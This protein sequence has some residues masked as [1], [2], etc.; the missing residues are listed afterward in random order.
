MAGKRIV[1]TAEARSDFKATLAFY[2]ERNGSSTY[3]RKLASHIL[4]AIEKLKDHS[5]LGVK[6][7]DPDVRILIT[8]NFSIYYEPREEEILVL[9]I[10]DAR[11]DPEELEKY[12]S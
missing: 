12:L 9:I 5:Y 1:W 8:G 11:R 2:R 4:Q 6:T 3:S 10:W 7:S